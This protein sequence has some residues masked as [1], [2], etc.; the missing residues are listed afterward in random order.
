MEVL[1]VYA[2]GQFEERMAVH[3]RDAFPEQ[4]G[5]LPDAELRALIGQGI[6]AASSYEITEERD[7]QRYLDYMMVLSPSFD[8]RPETA[9]AGAVLRQ[10]MSTGSAKMMRLDNAYLA[11]V[12]TR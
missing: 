10:R 4:A 6:A 5:Q 9:W 12:M 7:V 3:L 1:S 8:T 2:L 11:S